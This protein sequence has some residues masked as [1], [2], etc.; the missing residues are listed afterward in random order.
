MN[1][2]YGFYAIINS[3]LMCFATTDEYEDYM[4]ELRE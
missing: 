4:I 3:I 2:T 1:N